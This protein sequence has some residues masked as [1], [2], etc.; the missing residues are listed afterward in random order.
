[1]EQYALSSWDAAS[2]AVAWA[3]LAT[4]AQSDWDET[5][6]YA[7][8]DYV[9]AVAQDLGNDWIEGLVILGAK[10]GDILLDVTGVELADGS[11]YVGLQ[12]TDVEALRE[13]GLELIF[14]HNHPNGTEAS[15]DDLKR[16]FDAGAKLL[17]V[18]TPQGQEYVY[19]RGR[20][21]MVEVRDE[22]ASYE[23]GP[24]NPEE[25]EELRIRSEAQAA[26][27]LAD[28]PEFIFRQEKPGFRV[29]LI[30]FARTLGS[31]SDLETLTELELLQEVVN[32]PELDAY[33]DLYADDYLE[34]KEYVT[35]LKRA[36]YIRKTTEVTGVDP[37]V[38]AMVQLLETDGISTDK[39]EHGWYELVY[40]T[41]LQKSLGIGQIQIGVAIDMLNKYQGWFDD[42]NLPTD[43]M[44]QVWAGHELQDGW[45]NYDVGYQLYMN[46][47][48]NIRVAGA[49]IVHLQSEVSKLLNSVGVEPDISP[50]KQLM[51]AVGAYNQGMGILKSGLATRARESIAKVIEG[52]EATVDIDYVL[53]VLSMKDEA[54]ER[55]GLFYGGYQDEG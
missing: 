54:L 25:T 31:D 42:L 33:V 49:L 2:D 22:K 30:Q 41:S 34:R 32:N 6:G 16:A 3:T 1:M 39:T 50:H 14:V 17:I 27:Y 45:S 13:L 12:D 11:Q 52:V 20:Y 8:V 9:E 24:E 37:A 26:A 10:T 44:K 35:I 4:I 23:V 40:R 43:R 55:Y 15:Y 46:E 29:K 5:S 19:I 28:A 47:A 18:I 7:D 51:L 53:S 21:G 36:S 38:L 48:F